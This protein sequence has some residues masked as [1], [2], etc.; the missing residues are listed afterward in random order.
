[1]TVI[2]GELF[3]LSGC[4][5]LIRVAQVPSGSLVLSDPAPLD[6]GPFFS[7]LKLNLLAVC[8]L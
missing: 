3:P 2:S 7:I 5:E 4:G 1:V 6:P 8:V